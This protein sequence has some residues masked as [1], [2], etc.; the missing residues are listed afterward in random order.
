V[1]LPTRFA[2]E[3]EDTPAEDRGISDFELTSSIFI[4]LFLQL[5]VSMNFTQN[6]N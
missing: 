5:K 3:E 4:V 2:E 1:A 6:A